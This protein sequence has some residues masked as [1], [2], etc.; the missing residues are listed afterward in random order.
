VITEN[1]RVVA[2]AHALTAGDLDTAGRLMLASHASL[3][4][5]YEVSTPELNALV[6]QAMRHGA[7]GA[8]LL[9]GGF[10]GSV[11]A[12]TAATNA[13]PEDA[14]LVRPSRGACVLA[15]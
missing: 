14:I 9:G 10:G 3:R 11:V 5:D 12:L 4:D 15:R 1:E 6:E 13:V 7:Y 2:F 8:R